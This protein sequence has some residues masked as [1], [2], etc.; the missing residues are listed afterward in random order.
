[1]FPPMVP[2]RAFQDT[3]IMC[4]YRMMVRTMHQGRTIE[5]GESDHLPS[6]VSTKEEFLAVLV[7]KRPASN[8]DE[9]LGICKHVRVDSLPTMVTSARDGASFAVLAGTPA[10]LNG[11]RWHSNT[12][13][14]YSISKGLA[15]ACQIS[16]R[17]LSG[18]APT[19]RLPADQ[20]P[21]CHTS[22]RHA[23]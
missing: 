20:N 22:S 17:Q 14:I 4:A 13:A 11:N 6:V 21:Y 18:T 5:D 23:L 8:L 7:D 1:M 16:E 3:V 12:F 19:T 2:C 10:Q 15:V 9:S